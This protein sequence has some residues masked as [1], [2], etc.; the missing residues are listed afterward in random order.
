MPS[1]RQPSTFL[2]GRYCPPQR[3][4][5]MCRLMN[6]CTSH[7]SSPAVS[8]HE[9]FRDRPMSDRIEGPASNTTAVT[10]TG[11]FSW[12]VS[13]DSTNG[14][15]Q[16]ISASCHETSSLT[17]AP[18]VQHVHRQVRE[19]TFTA[20]GRR[21][22]LYGQRRV[23]RTE[24]PRC[25][26]LSRD[27]VRSACARCGRGGGLRTLTAPDQGGFVWRC[28]D[29]TPLRMNMRQNCGIRASGPVAVWGVGTRGGRSPARHLDDPGAVGGAAL[30]CSACLGNM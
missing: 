6:I 11:T 8:D 14:A 5:R 21:G 3:A 16:D 2:E 25:G 17:L 9:R 4:G 29:H 12:S 23:P 27:R 22:V 24:D 18:C 7:A 19:F 15:Q 13:Y 20:P 10:V 30:D 28:L 1:H 26:G